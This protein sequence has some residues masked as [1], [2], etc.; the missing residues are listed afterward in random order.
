MTQPEAPNVSGA[1]GGKLSARARVWLEAS[2]AVLG[3][4]I[5]GSG[6]LVQQFTAVGLRGG[7]QGLVV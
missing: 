5:Y 4:C 7:A 1:G 6:M 3:G 2:A